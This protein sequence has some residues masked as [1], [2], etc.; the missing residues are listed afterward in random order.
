MGTSTSQP[1]PNR[2]AWNSVKRVLASDAV[3]EQRVVNELWTV[4]FRDSE[5]SVL[6]QLSS[7]I[8]YQLA[9]IASKAQ[10]AHEASRLANRA[11][12]ASKANSIVVE[13]AKRALIGSIGVHDGRTQAFASS[14]FAEIAG[15]YASRDLSGLVGLSARLKDVS[16]A[17]SFKAT[18]RTITRS[19]VAQNM[20]GV[21]SH[22]AWRGFVKSVSTALT[23]G[24][25]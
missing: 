21:D 13:L 4:A 25:V 23:G 10:S 3:P 8:V 5:V 18:L 24:R 7:P 9:E 6:E 1:S 14:V 2:P 15:Y 17:I 16:H 19:V 11:I 12:V 20:Q 22:E